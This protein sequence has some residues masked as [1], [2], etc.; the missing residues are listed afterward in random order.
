MIDSKNKLEKKKNKRKKK[1]WPIF[2]L[3][4]TLLLSGGLAYSLHQEY[5]GF[6]QTKDT[7]SYFIYIKSKNYLKGQKVVG[8]VGDRLYLGKITHIPGDKITNKK[9]LLQLNGKNTLDS[10]NYVVKYNYEGKDYQV[11]VDK[12]DILGRY[13]F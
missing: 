13:Y 3:L 9:I 5:L 7:K 11:L 10:H 12:N 8:A 6:V 1:H 2:L 4:I